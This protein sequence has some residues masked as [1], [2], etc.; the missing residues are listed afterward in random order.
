MV[1]WTC[2]IRE[3]VIYAGGDFDAK[4]IPGMVVPISGITRFQFT[5]LRSSGIHISGRFARQLP[6]CSKHRIL[7][8]VLVQI[9]L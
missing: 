2:G 9:L 6:D 3:R 7:V 5:V 8:P 4:Y 1:S